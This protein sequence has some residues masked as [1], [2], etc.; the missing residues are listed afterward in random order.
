MKV[1]VFLTKISFFPLPLLSPQV[2]LSKQG[3]KHSFTSS[4]QLQNQII[5]TWHVLKENWDLGAGRWFLICHWQSYHLFWLKHFWDDIKHRQMIKQTIF[6][7]A[8]LEDFQKQ[9]LGKFLPLLLQ[10]TARRRKKK[11]GG[12]NRVRG[13][14]CHF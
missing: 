4:E 8:S 6:L 13:Y 1:I 7:I 10:R 2:Y 9:P 11:K 5:N 12:N 14:K 3:T